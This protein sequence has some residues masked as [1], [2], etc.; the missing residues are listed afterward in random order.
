MKSSVFYARLLV[1][2]SGVFGFLSVA[3]VAPRLNL[4]S[5]VIIP[6]QLKARVLQFAEASPEPALPAKGIF[7]D[8]QTNLVRLYSVKDLWRLRARVGEWVDR[9]GNIQCLNQVRSLPPR[10]T[11]ENMPRAV[12]EKLFEEAEKD[13]EADDPAVRAAWSAAS[14]VGP[15]AQFVKVEAGPTYC[16]SFSLT[17]DITESEAAALLKEAAASL[18][19]RLINTSRHSSNPWWTTTTAHYRFSTNLNAARGGKFVK[20]VER[21]MEAMHKSYALYVP[22]AGK[23]AKGSV[24][25]FKT[26]SDYQIYRRS[27]GAMD[28]MSCGLWDPAREELLI[29]AENPEA[30]CETMR[31]EAFHQYLH[32][33]RNCREVSPWFNE[34]HATFFESVKYNPARDEVKILDESP[35][36]M[37]LSR[38]LNQYAPHLASILFLSYEDFYE[39]GSGNYTL[40][41]ALTYFLE[42]GAYTHDRYKPYREIT[43]AYL[44]A[45]DAGLSPDEATRQAWAPVKD[46]D[47]AKD[48]TTFW[49]EKRKQALK[50]QR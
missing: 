27:T 31:H 24:R 43:S 17:D 34:G 36:A 30:A 15:Y 3:A 32:Y 48:F 13:F 47:L 38:H 8:A 37:D 10:T 2:A 33:A 35:R 46:R 14:G 20:D 22:S 44:K 28:L 49:L 5:E 21:L 50:V 12:A 39:G 23:I 16:V 6:G 26:L 18:S 9:R 4:E 25:L 11:S 7:F 1:F 45:L 42:R 19:S 29:S 40:A 41:W